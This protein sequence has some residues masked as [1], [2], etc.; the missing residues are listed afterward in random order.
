MTSLQITGC[1]SEAVDAICRVSKSVVM[2]EDVIDKP[3]LLQGL[4]LVLTCLFL[5]IQLVAMVSKGLLY[6]Q[7]S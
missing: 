4:R 5:Q 7:F 6:V 3:Q 1:I 2:I